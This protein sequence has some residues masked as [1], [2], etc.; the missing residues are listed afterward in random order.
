MP[1]GVTSVLPMGSSVHYVGT[2]PMTADPR[3]LTTTPQGRSRDY[4][5]LFVVDGS[6]FP[7]LPAKNPTFTLM[8]NAVRIAE[9]LK[10]IH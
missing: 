10:T 4:P 1:P 9:A 5:N 6:T 8:A 2:L 3:P 7:I